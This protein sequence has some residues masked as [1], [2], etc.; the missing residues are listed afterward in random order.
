MI[1]LILALASNPSPFD[2][3]SNHIHMVAWPTICYI[4]WKAGKVWKQFLDTATKTVG[5]IDSMATNHFPHME[6]SLATQD[7]LMAEMTGSLKE[8]AANTGRRRSS[9]FVL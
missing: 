8:I 4:A 7:K 5:Q 2:W 9:D 1:H 6:A 3:A